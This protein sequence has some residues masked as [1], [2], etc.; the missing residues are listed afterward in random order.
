MLSTTVYIKKQIFIVL[1]KDYWKDDSP[2]AILF[3][4]TEVE[5]NK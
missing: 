3:V 5:I 1:V 2:L 4:T